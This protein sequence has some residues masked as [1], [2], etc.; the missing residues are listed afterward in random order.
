MVVQSPPHPTVTV[1]RPRV[2]AP[3]AGVIEEARVRQRLHR[4]VAVAATVVAAV[5]AATIW[6]FVGGGDS[7][8]RDRSVAVGQPVLAIRDGYA[9]VNGQPLRVGVVP[10]LA[11]GA[12]GV[13][14]TT[15]I[16]GG[17]VAV[18]GGPYLTRAD[19]VFGPGSHTFFPELRVGVGGEVDVALVG[20][21]VASMHVARLGTFKPVKV[22]GLPPNERAVVFYRPPGSRGTVLPPGFGAQ[23][24]RGLRL[25]GIGI[26]K[27]LLALT[28]AVYDSSGR[29]IPVRTPSHELELANN[30]WK[31]PATPPV[32]GRC[33]VSSALS[34]VNP[35]W[36]QVATAI[37]P[38]AAVS[39]PAFLSCLDTWYRWRGSSL[40]VG[41]LLDAQ[42][43]GHA[44]APL[45]DETA[46]PGHPGLV[47]VKAV[48]SE[49]RSRGADGRTLVHSVVLAPAAVA[50]RMGS[51]WLIVRYGHSLAQRIQFLDSLSITRLDLSHK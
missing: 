5:I 9:Y 1:E 14:V 38:D 31:A 41:V 8:A 10:G 24:L 22:L 11:A 16:L 21:N 4:R 40:E 18:G 7:T 15:S 26:A 50:R 37:T 25:P 35:Q 19:P 23:V 42:A 51:A 36:G 48:R 43:P 29:L 2:E 34:G 39:V 46:L 28:E 33:A 6:A 27:H 13:Q 47:E 17:V 49:F 44:P 20:A 30:Y 45:W 32:S 12:V 3:D